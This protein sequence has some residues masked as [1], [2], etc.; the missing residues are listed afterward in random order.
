MS[1]LLI[2]ADFCL[3]LNANLKSISM[4]FGGTVISSGDL[5]TQHTF[6]KS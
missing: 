3:I 1:E 6:A 2:V 4:P 5:T